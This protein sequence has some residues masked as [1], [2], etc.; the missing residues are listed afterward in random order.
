MR[1]HRDFPGLA[2]HDD[3]ELATMLGSEVVVRRLVHEWPLTRTE[4]L[5]LADGRRLAYKTQ[6]P[7]S[8]EPQFYA[9]ARSPLLVEHTDLGRA[10]QGHAIATAWIDGPTLHS[11]AGDVDA[12]LRCA[13]RVTNSILEISGDP[14]VHLDL[15]TESAWQAAVRSTSRRLRALIRAG[16]FVRIPTERVDGLQAW[17]ERS[18]TIAA[19]TA[20]PGIVHGDLTPEEIFLLNDGDGADEHC[21]VVD[22]QR[23]VRGPRGL[24]L[25]ALLRARGIDPRTRLDAELVRIEA[26]PLLH[27]AALAAKEIL[28]SMP[29][30]LPEEWVLTSLDRILGPW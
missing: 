10:G 4:E 12:Y 16:R 14:P 28:P 15:S 6:L 11:S 23:P 26:F 25:V 29:P 17:A 7:P 30:R 9:R 18:A 8:V 22:W 5:R 2:V 19:V 20:D 27:W 1:A 24:D 21:R 13:D 3:E